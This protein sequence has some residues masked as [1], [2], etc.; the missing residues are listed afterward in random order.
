MYFVKF[1]RKKAIILL[2]GINWLILITQI[3]VFTDWIYKYS[4]IEVTVGI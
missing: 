1:N 4:L 2:S 3:D